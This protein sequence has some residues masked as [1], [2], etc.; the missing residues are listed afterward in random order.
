MN[1]CCTEAVV[2]ACGPLHSEITRLKS[3][4]ENRPTNEHGDEALLLL[5]AILLERRGG[6]FEWMPSQ[7]LWRR[8]RALLVEA[9]R[10]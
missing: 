9:G 5:K 4:L 10:M 1:T 8:A 2:C 3:D 7:A 6:E